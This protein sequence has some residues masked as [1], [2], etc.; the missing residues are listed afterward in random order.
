V[1]LLISWGLFPGVLVLKLLGLFRHV[2]SFIK[3]DD[4]YSDQV[5][6]LSVGQPRLI[7][8]LGTRSSQFVPVLLCGEIV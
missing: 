7:T 1:V 4:I 6:D 2:K 3:K 5:I 8:H